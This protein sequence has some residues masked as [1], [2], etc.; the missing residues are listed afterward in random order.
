V[1]RHGEVDLVAGNGGKLHATRA[2]GF[3]GEENCLG[4]DT[5]PWHAV[6]RG[7]GRLLAFPAA[8]LRSAP[9]VMWKLLETWERRNAGAGLEE[10]ADR[11]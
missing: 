3:F 9:V 10:G 4:R 5:A 6:A 1:V 7:A 8:E 2:G 11:K